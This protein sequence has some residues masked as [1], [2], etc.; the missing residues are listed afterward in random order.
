MGD[1]EAKAQ[2]GAPVGTG[3][4]VAQQG[5]CILS[6]AARTGH[7]WRT[8]WDHPQ[9]E[10]LRGAR[11]HPGVLLPGDRVF[12]PT[13]RPKRI[14]LESGRRYRVVVHGQTV[15]LR[16]RM[17]DADG[18]P[19][20]RATFR[21]AMAEQT[22]DLTTDDDG[23]LVADVPVREQEARLIDRETAQVYVLRIGHLDP[24]DTPT[25]VQK[26]LANLGY[27][28]EALEDALDGQARGSIEAFC[29]DAE[30]PEDAD[31][32][33]V[34]SRLESRNPWTT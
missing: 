31:L 32:N 21:L 17:L 34:V 1:N 19:M 8:L 28:A 6:I 27:D 3:D 15:P 16:L 25:G 2:V 24:A 9:N 4:Y 23:C 30:L 20:P 13:C 10:A 29:E 7:L 33:E 5:E 11:H 26:R 22:I 18:R 12:V 14:A